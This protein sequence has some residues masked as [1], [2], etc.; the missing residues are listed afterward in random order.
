MQ[1]ILVDEDDNQIGFAEKMDAHIQGLL[2]RAFSIFVFRLNSKIELLI[3]KRSQQKYHFGNLWT[4]TCCS[5]PKPHSTLISDATHRLEEEMGFKCDLT[6]IGKFIYKA[7][8]E[9]NLIEHELDH[10]L[11]TVLPM[12][13]TPVIVPNPQEVSDY[14]W[15]DLT[16]LETM[17][18]KNQGNFTP[19]FEKA[20][21]LCKEKLASLIPSPEEPAEKRSHS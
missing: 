20:Y 18:Q 6:Y 9:N 7:R 13:K 3:Q 10:V 4:N 1:L 12:E 16:Q 8:S 15:I 11:A 14:K 21:L 2:H 5:H 17:M 19:W